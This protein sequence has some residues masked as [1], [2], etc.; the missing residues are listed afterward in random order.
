MVI[1]DATTLSGAT[2]LF[3]ADILELD[4]ANSTLDVSDA[5]TLHSRLDV[6]G[7]ATLVNVDIEGEK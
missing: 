3:A 6:I 5:N 4:L 2:K 7:L 1:Y